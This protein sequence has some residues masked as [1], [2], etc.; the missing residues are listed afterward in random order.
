[1]RAHSMLRLPV[2]PRHLRIAG[3]LCLLAMTLAALGCAASTSRYQQLSRSLAGHGST[4]PSRD[5]ADAEALFAGFATL[6]R[7]DY[8]RALMER[9]PT[10]QAEVAS[11]WP[12]LR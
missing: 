9:N 2:R 8:V 7:A 5:G 6:E 11:N 10:L 3:P 1:M 4:S 12:L